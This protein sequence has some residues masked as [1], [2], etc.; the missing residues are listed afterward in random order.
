[1]P[2]GPDN[3]EE[4]GVLHTPA[5]L[6]Y[7]E[8]GPEWDPQTLEEWIAN[9]RSWPTPMRDFIQFDGWANHGPPNDHSD[10]AFRTDDDGDVCLAGKRRDP[11]RS[12][13][14][15]RIQIADGADP[16]DVLRVLRKLVDWIERNDA[17]AIRPAYWNWGEP[18][19][20]AEELRRLHP[21]LS[22]PAFE[23]EPPF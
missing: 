19:V 11:Q 9:R 8:H 22:G 16:A 7:G 23:P 18:F 4:C 6:Q 17:E 12:G 10:V 13:T 5:S 20:T 1:M 15:I 3:C 14:T 21:E 2:H